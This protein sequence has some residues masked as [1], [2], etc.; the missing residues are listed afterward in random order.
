MRYRIQARQLL[1]PVLLW[2]AGLASAQQQ[3]PL[4][5]AIDAA[6]NNAVN[7]YKYLRDHL[8][9]GVMPKTFLATKKLET[10]GSSWWTSG[11]YPGSLLYLYEYSKDTAM[12]NEANRR[13]VLLEKEQFNKGTHDLGFM[14]FCSFGNANRLNPSKA[15]TDIL[16]NSARSLST[17]FNPTVGCIQSWNA[18][19]GWKFPVIIDN[20]MNLELL[21]WATKF[22]GDS[23]FYK[24]AV[25]HANTTIKNHYRADH[26]SW[27]VVDYDPE[28]G[29][30]RAKQTAQGFADSSAWARGQA[31]GLYGFT[32]MYRSTKDKKY[33]VQADAIAQFLLHHPNLPADKIPYWDYNSIDI[34]ATYRDASAAAITASALLELSR[35]TDAKKSAQYISTAE[36]IIRA[37]SSRVYTAAPGENGGFLLK[38]STGNLPGNS[39][40]DVPLTYADY[41]YIEA[42]LRYK[43][44]KN[45]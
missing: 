28:T 39:E 32:V 31:W 37:L 44:L 42:M 25:T 27:H 4:S 29:A 38:H 34:P 40:V 35:Y 23:S 7:Q 33:L 22:T 43:Q 9:P 1:L 13:L 14:M 17:R 36:Q 3:Q 41:Y 18:R 19:N 20:M 15:Y 2:I 6:L 10:S 24:I 45:K 8:P 5:K 16:V 12:L 30:V 21:F 26:S 11:F